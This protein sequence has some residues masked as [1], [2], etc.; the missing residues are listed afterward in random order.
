MML[1]L[2]VKPFTVGGFCWYDDFG[3]LRS[4]RRYATNYG[5]RQAGKA[6]GFKGADLQI[7]NLDRY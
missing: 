5:A 2:S 3:M 7:V 1:R 4:S 6:A